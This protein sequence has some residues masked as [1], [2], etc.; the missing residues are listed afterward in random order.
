MAKTVDLFFDQIR[1]IR[2]GN[3]TTAVI[4]SVKVQYHGQ[5]T[6]IKHLARTSG[7]CGQPISITPYDQSLVSQINKDLNQAGFASYVFSKTTVCVNVPP[8]SGEE[9]AKICN[10]VKKIGEDAKIAIRNIRKQF[11]NSLKE[12]TQ[13]ERLN[14]EKLLQE[15]TD[16]SISLITEGVDDKVSEL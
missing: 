1:N 12:L 16:L 5:K 15:H 2:V 10:Y 6:P 14:A 8:M 7:G 13:D 11:R 4:D 9:V 3:V